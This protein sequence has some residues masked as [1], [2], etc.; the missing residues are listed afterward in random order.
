MLKLATQA[1]REDKGSTNTF[2]L[3]DE[4]GQEAIGDVVDRNVKR[5]EW[6]VPAGAI[7]AVC[8]H[9]QYYAR[10]DDRGPRRHLMA[11]HSRPRFCC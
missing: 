6:I 7:D 10:I 5:F 1:L 9:I 2:G 11:R 4:D 8:K 3:G